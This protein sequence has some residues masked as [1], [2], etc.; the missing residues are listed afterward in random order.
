LTY[1]DFEDGFGN[2]TDGG[3]YCFL[4]TGGGF[5][6]QGNNAADIEDNAGT[7]SSFY[8]TVGIDV[9][10]PGYTQI[11]I[12][13]WFYAVSM[14]NDEDF[15]VEYYDG[16]TW[17]IVADYDVNEE[18]FNGQFYFEEITIEE[19]TYTFPSNMKIRFRCDA[20]GSGDD[21]YIDEISVSAQ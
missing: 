21:V 20:S 12:G 8:H 9:D 13:F 7:S 4:Y 3:A 17:H 6:H 5:A 16:T 1:D 2:Y 11:K 19:G 15:F 18:F 14:D 10:T